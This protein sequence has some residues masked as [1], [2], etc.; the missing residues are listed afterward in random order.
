MY[1]VLH[2]TRNPKSEGGGGRA[3]LIFF[4][5]TEDQLN[6]FMYLQGFHCH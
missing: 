6:D 1:P 2:V 3:D 4:I 5:Q